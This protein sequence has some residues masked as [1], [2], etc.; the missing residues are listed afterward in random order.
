MMKNILNDARKNARWSLMNLKDLTVYAEKAFPQSQ[1]SR[2]STFQGTWHLLA[3][4]EVMVEYVGQ[5]TGQ[6]AVDSPPPLISIIIN[7]E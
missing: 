7:F 4:L 3:Q 6:G 1:S 5:A 2:L